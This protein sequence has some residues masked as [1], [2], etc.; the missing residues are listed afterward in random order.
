VPSPCAQV[1]AAPVRPSISVNPT[2]NKRPCIT[3]VP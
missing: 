3:D 2:V 1:G